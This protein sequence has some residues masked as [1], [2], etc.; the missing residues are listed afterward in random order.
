MPRRVYVS[1]FTGK[2]NSFI[3]A[4]KQGGYPV[5]KVSI[6]IG[7]VLIIAGCATSPHATSVKIYLQQNNK[8][9]VLS[10]AR[11][12][13]ADEPENLTAR[14]WLGF[15]YAINEDYIEAANIFDEVYNKNPEVFKPEEVRKIYKTAA[16]AAFDIDGIVITLRNAVVQLSKAQKEEEALRFITL[17][18]KIKVEDPNLYLLKASIEKRTNKGDFKG[19][20]KRGLEVAPENPDLN[21]HYGLALKEDENYSEALIYL[22]KASELK[23]DN[24]D[25]IFNIGVVYFEIDSIERSIEEFS[26]VVRIDSSRADAWLNL[27]VSAIKLE[28]YETAEDAFINY[29]KLTP[30]D[31][32]G[33]YF[34]AISILNSKSD[35]SRALEAI[36]SAINLDPSNPDYYNIKGMVL[37][38]QGK[39]EESLEMFKKA[40]ELKKQK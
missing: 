34:L 25:I 9:K 16:G 32:Q 1:F 2:G 40:Q 18:T 12:W 5:K 31:A 17:A 19:T 27:G 8:A 36:E 22:K 20:L 7:T 14:M 4:K 35:L 3:I 38:E 30:D 33:F 26:R 37:K 39:A 21:L 15:A 29:T 24:P 11:A 28:R 6:S 13:V 10:E 23:P